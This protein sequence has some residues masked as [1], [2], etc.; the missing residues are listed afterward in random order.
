MNALHEFST[1][2]PLEPLA[3]PPEVLGNCRIRVR[4]GSNGGVVTIELPPSQGLPREF[5][6][7]ITH[8]ENQLNEKPRLLPDP[9]PPDAAFRRT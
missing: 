9:R 7:Q 2:F 3:I 6:A 5:W 8:L 1:Q 4:R